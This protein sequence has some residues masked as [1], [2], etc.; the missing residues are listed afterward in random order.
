MADKIM[1][2]RDWTQIFKEEKPIDF[3]RSRTDSGHYIVHH[4]LD[5]G[6]KETIGHVYIEIDGDYLKYIST[7]SR[8][9]EIFPPTYDFNEVDRRFT[10]YAHLRDLQLKAMNKIPVVNKSQLKNPNTM[11]NPKSNSEQKPKKENQLIFIEYENAKRDGHNITVVDSYHNVIGR[12]HKLYNDLTKRYEY[13]A[14]DHAGNLM[15]KADKQWELK[16]E[17]VKNR[18]HLLEEAH[19]RRIASKEQSKQNRENGKEEKTNEKQFR[20][21]P[22]TKSD[23]RKRETEKLRQDKTGKGKDKALEKVGTKSNDKSI[24]T[25]NSKANAREIEPANEDQSRQDKREQE[26]DDLREEQDDDRGDMDMDR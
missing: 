15:F 14:Y 25:D 7:N 2:E 6:T 10:R 22:M 19:Q 11:N 13:V 20:N 8:G 18:T 17:F 9:R 3:Y 16:N 4:F 21:Q 1:P 24:E 26:L 12:G 5:D 23:E